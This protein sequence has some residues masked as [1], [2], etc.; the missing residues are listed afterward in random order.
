MGNEQQ[1]STWL[2]IMLTA[3]RKRYSIPLPDFLA[4]T[5]KYGLVG[6]LL[7]QYELLHYYDN[8][9]IINDVIKYIEEQGGD[10]GELRRTA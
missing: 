3:I 6:F 4:I 8:D 9:Y 1:I 2:F 10:S 5:K 7:E